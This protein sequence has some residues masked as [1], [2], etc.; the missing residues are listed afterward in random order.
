MDPIPPAVATLLCLLQSD[1][2]SLYNPAFDLDELTCHKGYREDAGSYTWSLP[3]QSEDALPGFSI[4]GQLSRHDTFLGV[5]GNLVRLIG[6]EENA[7][8]QLNLQDA[9]P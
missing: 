8:H 7:V 5:Y 1:P 9:A 2:Y 3:C 4:V 6:K